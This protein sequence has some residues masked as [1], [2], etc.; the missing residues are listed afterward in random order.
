MPTIKKSPKPRA[1]Q[2]GVGMVEVLVSLL[3]LAIGLL[4]IAAM[5]AT[6]LRN[7]QSA[8]ERSEAVI[9]TYSILDA[10]RANRAQALAGSY[11]FNLASPC[12]PPT[13]TDL[14]DRDVVAWL[15]SLKAALGT[16]ACGAI[17]REGANNVKITV[18][19]DD[20]TGGTQGA[21]GSSTQQLVTRTQL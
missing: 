3:V 12:N 10:M 16:S 17:L 2:L 15:A 21:A 19:W 1:T 13:V 11:D 18:Q 4:G 8:L 14:G 6:A 20:S 9:Q 7:G 5:Q